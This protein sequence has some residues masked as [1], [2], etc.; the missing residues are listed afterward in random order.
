MRMERVARKRK[1]EQTFPKTFSMQVS[2]RKLR[3]EVKRSLRA[4]QIRVIASIRWRRDKLNFFK[5]D[6][7]ISPFSILNHKDWFLRAIW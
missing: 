3:G 7:Q 1:V 2:F 6:D 4:M 5:D